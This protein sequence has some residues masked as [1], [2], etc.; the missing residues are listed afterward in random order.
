MN[1][2]SKDH[3]IIIVKAF[4]T[5]VQYQKMILCFCPILISIFW[6]DL[7]NEVVIIETKKQ[8]QLKDYRALLDKELLK[9]AKHKGFVKFILIDDSEINLM[10]TL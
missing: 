4:N 2:S 8:F 6:T 10:M 9:I 5:L 7:S 1:N 3:L